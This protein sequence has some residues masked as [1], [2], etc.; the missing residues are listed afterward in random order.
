MFGKFAQNIE[1]YL[2]YL[3]FI[4]RKSDPKSFGPKVILSKKEILPKGNLSQWKFVQQEIL[5]KGNLTQRKVDPMEI[6]PTGNLT[7]RK[8][9]PMEICQ[10]GNLTQRKVDPRETWSKGK[11]VDFADFS[12]Y[13]TNSGGKP[14]KNFFSRSA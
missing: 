9:D 12:K 5:P 13:L 8:F 6:C 10:E 1:H 3:L 7:Q 4:L 14:K 11:F 2:F